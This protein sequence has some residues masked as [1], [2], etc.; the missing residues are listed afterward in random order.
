MTERDR[1]RTPR[2]VSEPTWVRPDRVSVSTASSSSPVRARWS[3]T[4]SELDPRFW[5]V[6]SPRCATSCTSAACTWS[7]KSS[8]SARVRPTR[9]T[10]PIAALS[11]RAAYPSAPYARSMSAATDGSVTSPGWTVRSTEGA[12]KSADSTT[13]VNSAVGDSIGAARNAAHC[14]E[15]AP[16]TVS[17]RTPSVTRGSSC[18]PSSTWTT[19]SP[20]PTTALATTVSGTPT[21]A[22]CWYRAPPVSNATSVGCAVRSW[23]ATCTTNRPAL[24]SRSARSVPEVPS[25]HQAVCTRTGRSAAA[26]AGSRSSRSSVM[27]PASSRT[28]LAVDTARIAPSVPSCTPMVCNPCCS[29]ATEWRGTRSTETSARMPSAAAATTMRRRADHA[30]RAR[31]TADTRTPSTDDRRGG[32]PGGGP[33]GTGAPAGWTVADTQVT[34]ARDVVRDGA[35]TTQWPAARTTQGA[36]CH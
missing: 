19:R 36:P 18:A 13:R 23:T 22:C 11:C 4:C 34:A 21:S 29:E 15:R 33:G 14:T 27:P 7:T 6:R 16:S 25:C 2:C 5:Y 1:S 17:T 30:F 28:T 35:H 20:A 3:S 9:C 10:S 26:C 31:G 32:G 8:P 12:R 24:P